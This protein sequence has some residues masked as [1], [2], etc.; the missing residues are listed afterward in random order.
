MNPQH[1]Q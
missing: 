1:D